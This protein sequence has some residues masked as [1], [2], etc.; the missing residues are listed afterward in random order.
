MSIDIIMLIAGTAVIVFATRLA[1][2]LI[3]RSGKMPT[4]LVYL[5]TVIPPLVLT[6]LVIYCLKD[7]RWA[8]FPYGAP[9]ILAL[10]VVAGVH[11]LLRNA[12]V[13]IVGGTAVYLVLLHLIFRTA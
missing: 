6:I 10:T 5:E 3:F 13:S 8:L 11:L 1:P 12:F 7:V 9:E 4:L 2:F